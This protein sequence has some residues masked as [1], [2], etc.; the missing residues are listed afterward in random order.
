M[1]TQSNLCYPIGDEFHLARSILK[2][3]QLIELA[4]TNY[5]RKC[6]FIQ[7]IYQSA[8]VPQA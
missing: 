2:K 8:K 4:E 6:H 3:F 5:Q 7:K 1:L